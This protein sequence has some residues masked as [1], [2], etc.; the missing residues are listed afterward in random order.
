MTAFDDLAG[1]AATGRIDAIPIFTGGG[2]GPPIMVC[3]GRATLGGGDAATMG[4]IVGGGVVA[5]LR[6]D[7]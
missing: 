2:G 4:A 6:A 3:P 1:D 7:S 5:R